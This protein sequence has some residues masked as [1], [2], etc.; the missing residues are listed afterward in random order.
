MPAQRP[1]PR[2]PSAL[3]PARP[4]PSPPRAHSTRPSALAAPWI[5]VL[6]SPARRRRHLAEL[7]VPFQHPM[8][9]TGVVASIGS[10]QG[11]VVLLRADMDALPVRVSGGAPMKRGH[12]AVCLITITL[13]LAQLSW[14]PPRRACSAAEVVGSGGSLAGSGHNYSPCAAGTCRRRQTFRLGANSRGRCMRAAMMV[15]WPCCWEVGACDRVVRRGLCAS[16]LAAGGA[17]K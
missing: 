7:G 14:Q 12:S 3:A 8:A 10:G 9:G 2:P 13:E 6:M 16:V 1:R 15:T 4:M 11:P 5:S 17:V